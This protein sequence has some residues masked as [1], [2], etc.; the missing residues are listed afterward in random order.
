[1]EDICGERT[2]CFERWPT[3]R[4][5]ILIWRKTFLKYLITDDE[6]FMNYSNVV[7]KS[8]LSKRSEQ[9]KSVFIQKEFTFC[10]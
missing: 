4:E 5:A 3:F 2:R 6:Q 9:A 1:M 10:I 7:R 8:S